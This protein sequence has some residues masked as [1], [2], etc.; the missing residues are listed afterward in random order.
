MDFPYPIGEQTSQG[1]C[2]GTH[3]RRSRSVPQNIPDRSVYSFVTEVEAALENAKKAAVDKD[4]SIAGSN[5]AKQFLQLGLIDE[6]SIHLVPVLFGS[7]TQL[8]GD[9]NSE[10]ISLEIIE[11]IQIAEIIHRRFRADGCPYSIF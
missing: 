8:F 11:V 6:I 3:C 2:S 1:R 5:L 4:I 7:G 9:L 10:N